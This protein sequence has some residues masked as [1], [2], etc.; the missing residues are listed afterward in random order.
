MS[1]GSDAPIGYQ[2][3]DAGRA[4]THDTLTAQEAGALL[5]VG[6]NMVTVLASRGRVRGVK[7]SGSWFLDRRSVEAF[8]DGPRRRQGAP[9]PSLPVGPLLRQVELRGGPDACGAWRGSAEEQ[10][11]RR[12]AVDGRVTYDQMDVLAVRLL[13]MHPIELWGDAWLC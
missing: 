11:L 13:G 8:R 2:L 3:T 12:A 5:G 4:A 10:A 9:A 7:V 1:H 6:R